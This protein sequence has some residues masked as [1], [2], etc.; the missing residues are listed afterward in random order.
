MVHGQISNTER[1]TPGKIFNPGRMQAAESAQKEREALEL[2]GERRKVFAGQDLLSHAVISS[3]TEV[4]TE[5]NSAPPTTR[6]SSHCSATEGET[7]ARTRAGCSR[8]A[9]TSAASNSIHCTSTTTARASTSNCPLF[10]SEISPG[11]SP[12]GHSTSRVGVR[13][14]RGENPKCRRANSKANSHFGHSSTSQR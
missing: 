5:T 9:A 14:R 1:R 10:Q 6:G 13:V 3:L 4:L 7:A 12:R 8:A 11:N 2:I